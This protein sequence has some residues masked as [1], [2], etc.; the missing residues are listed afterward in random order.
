[1]KHIN[2]LTTTIATCFILFSGCRKT[3]EHPQTPD[4]AEVEPSACI[5]PPIRVWLF[6]EFKK[7]GQEPTLIAASEALQMS[8][9]PNMYA[10]HYENSPE[11]QYFG[12]NGE[13]TEKI[14]KAFIDVKR[15][16]NIQSNKIIK[17]AAHGSMLQDRSKILKMYKNVYSYSDD[18]ANLYADSIATLLKTYPQ[19][20]NGKHPAFT[21]NQYAIPDTTIANVGQIPAKIIICDGLLEGFDAIGYGDNAPQAILAHEFGHHIQYELGILKTGMKL[22][23]KTSRR[24]ELMADA[25]AAYFLAHAKGENMQLND[26]QQVAEVFFNTGDCDFTVDSHHGTPAQRKAATEWGYKLAK[27]AFN[28]GYILPSTEFAKLFDAELN[29]IVKK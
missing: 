9:L 21:F 10:L 7:W 23:P 13:Y 16:W 11:N 25:Y 12:V 17:V 4:L 20:L 29:N 27:N 3:N 22:V 26:L 28:K 15:F 8:N 1:M 19:Y 2:I 6:D 18:K 14:D 5:N 24:I